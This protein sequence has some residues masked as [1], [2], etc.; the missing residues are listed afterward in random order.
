ME[1]MAESRVENW[2]SLQRTNCYSF[3]P[4]TTSKRGQG[5]FITM[6]GRDSF[7]LVPMPTKSANLSHTW[8]M[9]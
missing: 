7:S 8:M 4:L 1:N 9:H 3:S 6:E 5:R 2:S